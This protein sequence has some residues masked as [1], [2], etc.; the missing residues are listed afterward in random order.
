[1]R[2]CLWIERYARILRS[3]DEPDE[4]VGNL[5]AQRSPASYVMAAR[6]GISVEEAFTL[7]WGILEACRVEANNRLN[8]NQFP[9]RM[10]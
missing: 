1:M 4:G 8:R 6:P 10:P 7:A 2:L 5:I 3:D 9:E